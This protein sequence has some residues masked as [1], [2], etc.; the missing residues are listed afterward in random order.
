MKY[1]Y[2]LPPGDS[3]ENQMRLLEGTI[4]IIYY[5]VFASLHW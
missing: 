3:S 1:C 2:N 5:S 4:Y